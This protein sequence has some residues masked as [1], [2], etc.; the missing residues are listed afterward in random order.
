MKKHAEIG[1]IVAS[2]CASLLLVNLSMDFYWN[3]DE[4]PELRDL[5]PQQRKA[6]SEAVTREIPFTRNFTDWRGGILLLAFWIG[7]VALILHLPFSKP[8]SYAYLLLF[9]G[10]AHIIARPFQINRRRRYY[11]QKRKELGFH[12]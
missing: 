1:R 6:L 11:A 8:I 2:A 3:E 10:I 5:S 4:I 9:G 12:S 7:V